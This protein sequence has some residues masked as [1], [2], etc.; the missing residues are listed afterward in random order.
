[1]VGHSL[2]TSVSVQL[3]TVRARREGVRGLF[4]WRIVCVPAYKRT[5]V[6][7]ALGGGGEIR[8]LW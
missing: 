2:C 4:R 6:Y 7:E 5:T 8:G 3:M 1:M